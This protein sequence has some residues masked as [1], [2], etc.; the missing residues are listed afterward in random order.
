MS[1]KT[2]GVD[3][4][5]AEFMLDLPEGTRILSASVSSGKLMLTLDTPHDFPEGSTLVYQSDDN[6]NIA[7]IGAN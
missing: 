4:P 6:G 5:T 7:L 2:V 1:K 3:I